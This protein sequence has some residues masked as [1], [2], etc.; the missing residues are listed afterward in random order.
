MPAWM[1]NALAFAAA[2]DRLLIAI[3]VLVG[4]FVLGLV[5]RVVAIARLEKLALKTGHDLDDVIVRSAKR[6][7]LL[8][9]TL[10]GAFL[11]NEIAGFSA[12]TDEI[13]DAALVI[14]LI[15]SLTFFVSSI[16][17][18]ALVAMLPAR[19]GATPKLTGVVQT[20]AR[21]AVFVLGGIVLLGTLGIS[22][23]PILTTLGVGG[24]AV[25]LGLQETLAN[26]F[27]GIH[28]TLSRNVRVGDF[29]KLETGQEG[30][31][32]DVAWR[33]TR[34]CLPSNDVVIVPNSKL[35]Q[36]IVTNYD[37]PTPET[38]VVLNL[39]VHPDT[40]L[41][42][43]ERITLEEAREAVK[44]VEGA[45]EDVEPAVRFHALGL[46]SADFTV[47]VRARA[48]PA[49]QALRHE[50]IRR[51]SARYRVERIV[52]PHPARAPVAE[53]ARKPPAPAKT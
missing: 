6:H 23:T 14:V 28:L 33:A 3:T 52:V 34:I 26:V 39:A 19:N 12:A 40:D 42:L 43:V 49:G 41:E 17:V 21:F 45:L 18:R 30:T 44:S 24:L 9:V 48:F 20:V 25:A 36:S 11:A 4:S 2:H 15:V 13:V 35:A 51:L 46:A 37:L 32:E 16:G 38:G 10:G 22:I 29:V 53:A 5:A 31:V 8:W 47:T 50:L 27:A 1:H 7:V